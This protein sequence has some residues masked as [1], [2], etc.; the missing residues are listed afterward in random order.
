MRWL[1]KDWPHPILAG[2]SQNV[3]LKAI[4]QPGEGWQAV[5]GDDPMIHAMTL[6]PR[7]H[8]ALGADGRVYGTDSTL[9]K[10]WLIRRD[11]KKTVLDS[12][13][14]GPTGIALSPDGLWVVARR[15]REQNALGL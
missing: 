14:E 1:W 3:F 13:L 9:G 7:A 8:R 4:L 2:Q 6:H 15:R 10:V 12:G 11:G 5:M